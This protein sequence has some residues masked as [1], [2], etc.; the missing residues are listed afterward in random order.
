M[1]FAGLLVSIVQ[2]L[3]WASRFHRSRPLLGSFVYSPSPPSA[4]SS[5]RSWFDFFI[6]FM[7]FFVFS[8]RGALVE[9]YAPWCGHCKKLAPEYEKLGT[10]FKKAKSVLIGKEEQRATIQPEDVPQDLFR[11]KPWGKDPIDGKTWIYLIND[12]SS[13][14]SEFHHLLQEEIDKRLAAA[15]ATLK[16]TV[17]EQKE[18]NASLKQTVDEQKEVIAGYKDKFEEYDRLFGQLFSKFK[19]T[20]PFGCMVCNFVRI[21]VFCGYVLNE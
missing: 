2:G 7:F 8:Y 13:Q 10:S 16:K 14:A 18:V 5:T 17:D 20:K 12:D 9:F 1:A 21:L 19:E 11:G 15:N 3:C 4:S 6:F